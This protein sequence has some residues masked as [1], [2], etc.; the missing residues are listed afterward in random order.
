[1][2]KVTCS[3]LVV[4]LSLPAVANNQ[5]RKEA[6]TLVSEGQIA[7][8]LSLYRQGAAETEDISFHIYA[9]EQAIELALRQLEDPALAIELARE[10]RP[11]ARAQ[12]LELMVLVRSQAHQ[13]AIDRFGEVEI[14]T[15]PYA[16]RFPGFYQRGIAHL[17][18]GHTDSAIA[19]LE[20]ATQHVGDKGQRVR[21]CRILGQ[22][23]EE[24]GKPDQALAVYSR[25][26]EVTRAN[27]AGRNYSFLSRSRILLERGDAQQSL[28][29]FAAIDYAGLP[30]DWWRG[31]FYLQHAKVQ[32]ALGNLGTAATLLTR[33]L[34]L[35][36]T[37]A[38]Q[39][40]LAQERIDGI[41][42][43]MRQSP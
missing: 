21:A 38:G 16:L 1:M 2:S 11:P 34:R 20:A 5:L 24:Q 13:S 9:I 3:L 19:D 10:A 7:E 35:P 8:A 4:L 41:I 12:A 15:W 29:D 25:A 43:S 22:L 31:Q 17:E 36:G 28:D 42:K 26:L 18:L 32:E 6:D 14:T 23:H 37:S 27:Y 40:A 30:S 39:Q 33:V